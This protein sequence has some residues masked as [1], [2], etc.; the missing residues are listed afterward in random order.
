MLNAKNNKDELLRFAASGFRD[1]TRIAA[2]SPEMWKDIFI[3]NKEACLKDLNEFKK[4]IEKFESIVSNE[5]DLE[6]YLQ[7]AS[8]LRSNWNE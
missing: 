3:D 1:F 7:Y 8:T 6:K 4:Q 2:S 5:E